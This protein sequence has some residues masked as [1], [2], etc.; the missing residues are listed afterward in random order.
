VNERYAILVALTLCLSP[1]LFSSPFE[2]VDPVL[3]RPSRVAGFLEDL[4]IQ[5]LWSRGVIALS[6]RA[7]SFTGFRVIPRCYTTA[8]GQGGFSLQ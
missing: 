6:L 5:P 3:C 4:L 1:S 8:H 2:I 7:T